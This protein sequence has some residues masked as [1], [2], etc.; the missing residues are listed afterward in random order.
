MVVTPGVFLLR[1]LTVP[2]SEA[3]CES[4]GSVMETYH[5]RFTNSDLDDNQVQCEMFVRLNG[6]PLGDAKAFIERS[7]FNHRKNFLL[8]DNAKFS[9]TSKVVKRQLDLKY[10][11]P[12][13]F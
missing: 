4:F 13:K 9:G 11:L 10:K 3:I 12:F 6:P 2:V 8:T 1:L 5:E 7:V